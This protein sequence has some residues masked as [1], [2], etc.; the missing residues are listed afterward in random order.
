MTNRI[1]SGV[2]F[3]HLFL[4]NA[5]HRNRNLPVIRS[6]SEATLTRAMN[7][8]WRRCFLLIKASF[9]SWLPSAALAVPAKAR[10][11]FF[12]EQR[13]F[14]TAY[15]RELNSNEHQP[16]KAQTKYI[17]K[18]GLA[19]S[20]ALTGDRSA[21]LN[22][23]LKTVSMQLR[24]QVFV[25]LACHCTDSR[26]S[27]VR[28]RASTKLTAFRLATRIV[29]DPTAASPSCISRD[30]NTVRC[31]GNVKSLD[32][33]IVEFPKLHIEASL[34]ASVTSLQCRA[35]V[36]QWKALVALLTERSPL[37]HLGLHLVIND[38]DD[39]KSVKRLAE[40][41]PLPTN[42]AHCKVWFV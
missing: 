38:V 32:L 18:M 42:S 33:E 37:K 26:Q 7:F 15:L 39:E 13:F 16:K 1:F 27:S 19:C 22:H 4:E 36:Q 17:E 3:K 28:F 2:H 24:N 35:G 21:K 12:S 34:L 25:Y 29:A 6:D 8:Y 14:R 9:Y 5:F 10:R 40:Q 20:V 11:R 23:L 31:M 41:I 30:L